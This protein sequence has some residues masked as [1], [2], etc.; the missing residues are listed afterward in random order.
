MRHAAFVGQRRIEIRQ[1]APLQDR[2]GET[3]VRVLGCALCGSDMRV[4]RQGWPVTPG[5][6]IVGIVDRPGDPKHGK[7][8]VVYIPVFCGRCED[9]ARGDTHLCTTHASLIGWQRDGGYAEWL[10]APDQCLLPVP[11]D[12]ETELAPLLL[13]VIGTTAH[14][15]RLARRALASGDVAVIG[16]GPIGL[17]GI[18]TAQHLGFNDVYVAEPQERRRATALRLGASVLPDS[19]APRYPLVL[20]TSGTNAGRQRALELTA[21]HGVCVFLGESDRWDI[22][23]TK[24]IRRKDF[25]VLRSFYFPVGEFEANLAILRADKERYRAF[26]DERAPLDELQRLFEA[27]AAGALIKPQVAPSGNASRAS[28]AS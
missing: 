3:R 16:A 13:D 14:A 1:G 24:T 9:C 21:A 6:E 17:G 25:F 15:I 22:E 7:R 12:I 5:H 4:W 10:V 20:E 2:P 27:F 23:E 11:D 18:L 26:V 8:V 28:R 19:A